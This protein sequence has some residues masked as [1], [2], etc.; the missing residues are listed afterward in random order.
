MQREPTQSHLVSWVALMYS[1]RE[2]L[3]T[4]DEKGTWRAIIR[5]CAS[6]CTNTNR[7][8]WYKVDRS[9]LIWISSLSCPGPLLRVVRDDEPTGYQSRPVRL[10]PSCR[11]RENLN[12][13][14]SPAVSIECASTNGGVGTP[15]CRGIKCRAWVEGLC[16]GRIENG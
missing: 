6:S 9:D 4:S 14:V 7:S 12:G 11:Q 16:S 13:G 10:F 5:F 8:S 3:N 1:F 2:W 15:Y